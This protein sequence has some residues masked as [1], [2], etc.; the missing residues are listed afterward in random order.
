MKWSTR[1][2]SRLDRVASPWLI[3]RLVDPQAAFVFVR[4]SELLKAAQSLA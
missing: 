2:N 1:S 3:R 4:E